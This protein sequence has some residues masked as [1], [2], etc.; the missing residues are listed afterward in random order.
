MDLWRSAATGRIDNLAR[1]T[2]DG[3]NINPNGR[4][5]VTANP[6][7]SKLALTDLWQGLLASLTLL[8]LDPT[9]GRVDRIDYFAFDG[10]LPKTVQFDNSSCYVAPTIFSHFDPV[11]PGSSSTF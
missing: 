7:R 6:E 3:L 10:M 8:C 11:H 2:P 5:V 4:W 9:T 1:F